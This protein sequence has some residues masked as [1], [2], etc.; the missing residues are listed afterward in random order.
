MYQRL[1]LY[2]KEM[3]PPLPSFGIAFFS[4]FNLY[5]VLQLLEQPLSHLVVSSRALAGSVTIFLFLLFLR[6]SDEFKDEETDR[7]LFPDRPL[8]SGRVLR[9]DLE[10]LMWVDV[11]LM[12]LLNFWLGWGSVAYAILL[13]YGFLMLH[14]FFVPQLISQ[15]LILALVTHNPSVL[16]LNLYVMAI[17]AQDFADFKLLGFE[18][19]RL[20]VLF[21]LPGL[22]WELA[23]KIRTPAD[24][25]DY[26]TYSK[27][28]GYRLAT[29][30]PLMVVLSH[31]FLLHSVASDINASFAFLTLLKAIAMICLMAYITFMVQPT[32][33]LST[34]LKPVTEAYMLVTTVGFFV[35]LL[36]NHGL[37]WRWL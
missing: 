10:W 1:W 34:R 26:E 21:W 15:R 16:F 36:W 6:I 35:Q 11:I 2:L 14:Y 7:R 12:F 3:Y 25:N 5:F 8:P 22:A 13:G 17:F 18:G 32:T 31:Y 37:I 30:L 20:L 33:F 28:F 23:R 29:L 27:I 24:E 19:G 4:F 9:S